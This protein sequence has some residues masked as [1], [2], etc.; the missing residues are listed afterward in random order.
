MNIAQLISP[1]YIKFCVSQSVNL[2]VCPLLFGGA[3]SHAWEDKHV[4]K[5]EGGDKHFQTCGSGNNEVNGQEEEDV[6]EANI[7]ASKARKLSAGA[8]F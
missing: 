5:Q 4:Y 2:S 3:F 8:R 7:L 6:S 1:K